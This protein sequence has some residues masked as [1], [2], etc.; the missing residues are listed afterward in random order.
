MDSCC[1]CTITPAHV[2]VSKPTCDDCSPFRVLFKRDKTNVILKDERLTRRSFTLDS[3]KGVLDLDMGDQ[4]LAGTVP[5]NHYVDEVPDRRR[6]FT[7]R[8][9]IDRMASYPFKPWSCFQ[10]HLIILFSALT[11]R[12]RFLPFES[13]LF[14]RLAYSA[15]SLPC[16]TN[17]ICIASTLT[18]TQPPL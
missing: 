4:L 18:N 9:P 13:R 7:S 10:C 14:F 17:C 3:I 8:W 12:R 1:T 6:G 11:T 2:L 16:L 15:E 5:P